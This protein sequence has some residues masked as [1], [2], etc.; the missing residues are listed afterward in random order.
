MDDFLRFVC[1]YCCVSLLLLEKENLEPSSTFFYEIKNI[2]FTLQK[3]SE[4]L[5]NLEVGKEE[6]REKSNSSSAI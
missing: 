5:F 6:N 2:F 1:F 3:I 4:K